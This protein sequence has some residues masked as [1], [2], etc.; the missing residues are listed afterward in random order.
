MSNQD[1]INFIEETLNVNINEVNNEV[2]DLLNKLI[3]NKCSIYTPLNSNFSVDGIGGQSDIA[4][5][6]NYTFLIPNLFRLCYIQDTLQIPNICNLL[7]LYNRSFNF[8]PILIDEKLIKSFLYFG[9]PVNISYQKNLDQYVNNIK[10]KYNF[11]LT[12]KR[13]ST[14]GSYSPAIDIFIQLYGEE[15]MIFQLLELNKYISITN[16]ANTESQDLCNFKIIWDFTVGCNCP[17]TD[18]ENGYIFG[19]FNYD[20]NLSQANGL[21]LYKINSNLQKNKVTQNLDNIFNILSYARDVFEYILLEIQYFLANGLYCRKDYMLESNLPELFQL[22]DKFYNNQVESIKRQQPFIPASDVIPSDNNI[23]AYIAAFI[24]I[25][26]KSYKNRYLTKTILLNG[27]VGNDAIV[28]F[29]NIN[30][31]TTF[32]APAGTINYYYYYLNNTMPS[33]IELFNNNLNDTTTYTLVTDYSY[34]YNNILSSDTD[35]TYN[36]FKEYNYDGLYPDGGTTLT[37]NN[38][39]IVYSF[40]NSSNVIKYLVYETLETYVLPDSGGKGVSL[41]Y[42]QNPDA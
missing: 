9:F 1:I 12:K 8:L 13:L 16:N 6:T 17:T 41:I 10:E 32:V 5:S 22:Y 23:S 24:Y 31:E 2:T 36:L 3:D 21:N 34:V 20:Y 30:F 7:L 40:F 33:P 18:F 19:N 4:Q 27:E 35:T 37:V 26:N 11:L 29:S 14:Y 42:F 25:Y 28:I 38:L 15:T 39:G